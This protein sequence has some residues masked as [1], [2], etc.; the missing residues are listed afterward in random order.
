M[1]MNL[2]KVAS[3]MLHKVGFSLKKHSPE[4]LVISGIAGLIGS[5]VW[6]C[7]NTRKLDEIIAT[8]DTVLFTLDN[9]PETADM[10]EED[11]AKEAAK[12]HV[13]TGLQIV[14]TYAPP[15]ALAVLSSTAILAS[16]GILR[17]RNVALTAAVGTLTQ[18]LQEYRDRVVEKYG[19]DV[20]KE[21]RFGTKEETIEE[22]VT[23]ENGKTKTVKKKEQVVD[24]SFGESEFAVIFDKRSREFNKNIEV[25]LAF[26]TLIERTANSRLT[27]HGHLFWNEVLDDLGLPRTVAGQVC[28]WLY[29]PS[30][31]DHEGDNYIKFNTQI[32]NRRTENGYEKIIVL[33]P[34]VDGDILHSKKIGRVLEK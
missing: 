29:D 31:K 25:S 5:S 1:K 15:I 8:R 3:T 6:A 19:P 7:F 27:T 20:D 30:D 18:T 11:I 13:Y 28:G 22:T 9:D 21:L 14:K 32:V 10:A 24:E 17:K 4:I 2:G 16:Y 26:L 33:D 12:I 34:N 23:D